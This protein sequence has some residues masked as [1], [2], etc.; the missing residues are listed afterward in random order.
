M[1]GM[2]AWKQLPMTR[3]SA[4][5]RVKTGTEPGEM[6]ALT[7]RAAMWIAQPGGVSHMH[8]AISCDTPAKL[9]NYSV[10]S[11]NRKKK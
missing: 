7:D 10:F 2:R 4:H 11:L 1:V 3:S 5:T 6:A 9:T 8:A